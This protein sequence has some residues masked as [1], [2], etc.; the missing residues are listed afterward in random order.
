[1][2]SKR[3]ELFKVETFA[4]RDLEKYENSLE[5]N[6]TPVLDSNPIPSQH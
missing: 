6:R 3:Y 5:N 1:M 4:I 2:N